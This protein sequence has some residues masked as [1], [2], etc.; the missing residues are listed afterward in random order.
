MKLSILAAIAVLTP[1]A[2]VAHDGMHANDAYA[3]STNPKVGAVFMQLENHRQV[4]CT[5]QGVSSDAAE[6]VELHTHTQEDGIMKMSRLEDGIAVAAGQIHDLNRGGD[7]VMMLGLS[8][9][10]TDGD[11]L[12]LTL[13]FGDCGTEE[14]QAVVDNQR[15]ETVAPDDHD[16]GDHQG[17]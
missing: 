15:E 6:R 5:L 10:L 2:A 13:D 8:Q 4:A 9:P 7:H 14:V 17:H 1:M 11:T 16:H 12:T 3:R